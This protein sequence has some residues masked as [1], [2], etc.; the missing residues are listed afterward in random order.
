MIDW[1]KVHFAAIIVC[2]LILS[3]ILF[4]ALFYYLLPWA[5]LS[6]SLLLCFGALLVSY[7]IKY[8]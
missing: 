2:A 4:G 1:E 8:N 6:I 5:A 7:N 3:A